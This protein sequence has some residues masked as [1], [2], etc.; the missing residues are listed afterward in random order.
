MTSLN[1][2]I[3]TTPPRASATVVLLRDG[4]QGLEVLLLRRHGASDVLGGAYVFPG[5]KLDPD[6]SAQSALQRL[7]APLELLHAR[8]GEPELGMSDAAG[9]FVAACRE[10]FEEAGVLLARDAGAEQAGQAIEY[11]RAGARFG[12]L[13]ARLDLQLA[14]DRLVPWSRWVTPKVPSMMRKRFDTRFF[15][16][17]LPDGQEACHDDHEATECL[18]IRPRSALE[19]YWNREL[20][21]APAQIMS[22]VHLARHGDV[23]GVLDEAATRPPPRIEPEPHQR[24]D[25]RLLVYPG[26][27]MHSVPARAMPGPT[28]LLHRDDRFEPPSGGLEGWFD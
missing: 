1:H 9:F 22:L 19:R 24:D 13:L 8:L 16:A 14:V 23:A 27:P 21:M 18:W 17:A 15:V 26:D 11:A 2:E 5:G 3:V 28:R 20:V 6:D 4:E 7:S 10:T 25:H 12:D